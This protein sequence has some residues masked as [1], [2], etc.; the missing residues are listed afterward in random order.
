MIESDRGLVLRTH[1]LRESAKIVSLLG[2]TSGR[3]RLVAHGARTARSR[4][5]ASLEPGNEIDLVF[6]QTPGRE[7]GTLREAAVRRAHLAGARRLDI[8]GA[9]MAV[10]ELLDRLVPEGAHEPGLAAATVDMLAALRSG[11]TR[12]GSLLL[13]YA[14]ELRLL[15]RLGAWPDLEA[16]AGCARVLG[17]AGG[18]LDV[19][20]GSLFCSGCGGGRGRVGLPGAAAV[21]LADLAGRRWE[22]IERRPTEP[23]ERRL[24]G[25]LLHRLLA[26]HVDRYRVPHALALLK[27]VDTAAPGRLSAHAST[28]FPGTA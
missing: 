20:A 17:P 15:D 21:L 24:A 11:T 22:E 26:A 14:F 27:K 2:F 4:F 28:A 16:C 5:A 3:L 18:F 12:A 25:V 6:A 10:L 23:H 9:G 1:H 19:C 7:L 8:L 13:F